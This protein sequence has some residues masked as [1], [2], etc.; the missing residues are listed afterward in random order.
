M[1][2]SVCGIVFFGAPHRGLNNPELEELVEGSPPE[3][4]LRDLQPNSSLLSSLDRIFPNACKDIKIISCYETEHTYTY[5][6]EDPCNP[7]SKW[8]KTGDPRF[9]VPPSSACLFWEDH[10]E[11]R[12]AI[13][14][15][16][17]G[18]AKLD[19]LIGSPYYELE[20][21]I[22]EIIDNAPDV[23]EKR[24]KLK[25][26]PSSVLSLLFMLQYEY[27]WLKAWSSY[28]SKHFL[29]HGDMAEA[30]GTAEKSLRLLELPSGHPVRSIVD[31]ITLIVDLLRDLVNRYCVKSTSQK[32]H[33][34]KKA[35]ISFGAGG[36]ERRAGGRAGGEAGGRAKEGGDDGSIHLRF[37]S[38]QF[39]LA[40]ENENDNY[41]TDEASGEY[42]VLLENWTE[43]HQE[44]LASLISRFHDENE[45]LSQW[46]H[47]TA[48]IDL[49]A[50]SKV[51]N[52]PRRTQQD[53]DK[54]A[55]IS[56]VESLYSSLS[57][58][59]FTK[60]RHLDLDPPKDHRVPEYPMSQ[61]SPE[62][63]TGPSKFRIL[64]P[65]RD[66]SKGENFDTKCFETSFA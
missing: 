2:Q 66:A 65:S 25:S 27:Y 8:V 50:S 23:M 26:G 12:I 46:S 58:R 49:L 21:G 62:G 47:H 24:R 29:H 19:D 14:K 56:D 10:H 15:D 38:I 36:A 42:V 20:R 39:P 63:E 35:L 59:A 44:H 6:L 60:K 54:L 61:L 18:I 7:Q 33:E 11:T 53:L 34:E 28:K 32:Q 4:L 9:L 43:P 52:N 48:S 1:Y 16:H 22:N 30:F 45:R 3:N 40:L 51:I 5:R 55:D 64:L 17:S 41:G 13:H 31:S 37:T 57:E